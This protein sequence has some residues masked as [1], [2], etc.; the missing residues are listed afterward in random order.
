[1]IAKTL[2]LSILVCI[3]AVAIRYLRTYANIYSPEQF[4]SKYGPTA[5][6]IGLGAAYA[7]ILCSNG[8]ELVTVARR[9]A[10]L[11]ERKRELVN[12]HQRNVSTVV[13]DLNGDDVTTTMQS[14]FEQHSIGL[15]VYN[16]AVFGLGEFTS[17]LEQQLMGVKVNVESLTRTAH[18]HC[19]QDTNTPIV[20]ISYYVFYSGRYR[21]LSCGNLWSYKSI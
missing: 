19:D 16:A 3:T 12:K 18:G 8:L 6:V 11:E 14:I 2:A 9:E 17:S 13:L 21:S 7:D 10:E 1:M 15:V 20:W 4:Q 5:V